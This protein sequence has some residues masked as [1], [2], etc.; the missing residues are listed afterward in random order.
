MLKHTLTATAFAALML[1][2]ALAQSPS[3]STSNM[4]RPAAA[5]P[6]TQTAP[7]PSAMPR[8]S[9]GDF[10]NVSSANDIRASKL[11]GSN[12]YGADN[13]KI[14]DVNDLL[15]DS[16]GNVRAVVVGVGGFLGVGEKEVAM[17][18]KS[19]NVTRT[20]NGDKIDKITVAYSKDQLKDA[21]A[22]KWSEASATTP[23]R[24]SDLSK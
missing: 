2:P 16:N 23:E 8:T 6:S 20:A 1:S 24:R 10:V 21:P 4:D 13:A 7:S 15:L 9:G 12:V 19:L 14:G 3:N 22:F 11:I 17:N 5:A 18:F